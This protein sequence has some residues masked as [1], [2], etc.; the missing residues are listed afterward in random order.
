LTLCRDVRAMDRA[1]STE[2]KLGCDVA[3]SFHVWRGDLPVD[4]Q[5]IT[6]MLLYTGSDNVHHSHVVLSV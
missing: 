2:H 1:H 5:S 6:C 4:L 3:K